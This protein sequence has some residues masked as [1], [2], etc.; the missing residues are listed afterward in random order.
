MKFLMFSLVVAAALVF[1]FSAGKSDLGLAGDNTDKAF[2]EM[3]NKA[4]QAVSEATVAL[5]ETEPVL[6]IQSAT[7]TKEVQADPEPKAEILA[8]ATEAAP[9]PVREAL[10]PEVA[11][12][13]EEILNPAN[14]KILA[15]DEYQIIDRERRQEQLRNLAEEMEML[16][17]EMA[18][19]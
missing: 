13:R 14:S 15:V 16:S 10:S 17:L 12:R 8:A 4:E 11:K 7:K 3:I 18:S 19:Q 5:Q 1:L 6:D 2:D 9:E